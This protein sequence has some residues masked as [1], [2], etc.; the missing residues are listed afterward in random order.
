MKNHN[1]VKGSYL[2]NACFD[3]SHLST[4]NPSHHYL[5]YEGYT[6]SADS[7]LNGFLTVK[8]LSINTPFQACIIQVADPLSLQPLLRSVSCF[9]HRS[10]PSLSIFCLPYHLYHYSRLSPLSI[11]KFLLFHS[12]SFVEI[13]RKFIEQGPTQHWCRVQ[14]LNWI[15]TDRSICCLSEIRVREVL[16][17]IFHFE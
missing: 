1:S 4:L 11:N 7:G 5:S 3:L 9:R 16:P 13:I 8:S 2:W 14:D 6:S 10:S 17:I 15:P 12:R